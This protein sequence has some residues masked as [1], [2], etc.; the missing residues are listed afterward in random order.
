MYW[1]SNI[2]SKITFKINLRLFQMWIS[3]YLKTS[4]K[5]HSQMLSEHCQVIPLTKRVKTPSKTEI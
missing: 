5:N 4:L 3:A 1:E 2:Y